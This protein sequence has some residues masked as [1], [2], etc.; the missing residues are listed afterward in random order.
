MW[1]D[2]IVAI[3]WDDRATGLRMGVT[4]RGWYWVG[5]RL[6]V[7]KRNPSPEGD[8]FLYYHQ[9]R[10]LFLQLRGARYIDSLAHGRV[11]P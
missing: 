1:D 11:F 10:A 4:R 8:G 5:Y 6:Y 3:L 2:T 9:A 7:G